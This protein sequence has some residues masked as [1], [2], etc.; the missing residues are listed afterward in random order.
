MAYHIEGT[1]LV[2]DGWENGISENPYK[3]SE[4]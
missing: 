4:A 3:G 2:I 1:D